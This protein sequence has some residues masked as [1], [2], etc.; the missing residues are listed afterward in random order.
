MK[1]ILLIDGNSLLFRS[2]YANQTRLSANGKQVN[3][4]YTFANSI[5]SFLESNDYYDVRI[6]FDKGKQTFRHKMY[7]DYK[8]GRTKTPEELIEQFPIAREF[9]NATGIG[10]CGT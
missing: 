5:L 1:K 3:G 8:G 10:F 2:F 7:D 9:V 6:A 4:V